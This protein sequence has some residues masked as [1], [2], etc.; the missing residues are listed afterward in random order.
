MTRAALM[1]RE[2]WVAWEVSTKR[3]VGERRVN[4]AR[5]LQFQEEV[6]DLC[7]AELHIGN[8]IDLVSVLQFESQVIILYP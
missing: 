7:L 2:V 6:A 4:K 3:H 5:S 8:A 1:T